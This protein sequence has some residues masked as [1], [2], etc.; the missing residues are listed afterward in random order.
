MSKDPLKLGNRELIS[1]PISTDF[2]DFIVLDRDTTI[3]RKRR[4]RLS[5]RANDL[6]SFYQKELDEL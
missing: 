6:I 4:A 1:T 2:I 5:D 3:D